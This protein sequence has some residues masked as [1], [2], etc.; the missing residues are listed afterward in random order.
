VPVDARGPFDLTLTP[1]HLGLGAS[2]SPQENFTGDLEW[3][4][5][6]AERTKDDGADGRLVQI[7]D[8][9]ESW[10]SW[11]MHPHGEELVVCV[12]GSF[13]L[14]QERDGQTHSIDLASGEAAINPVGVWHTAD[15][16]GPASALFVTSGLGTE[17]R[18]R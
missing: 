3:Y 4:E 5:R 1:V 12:S 16:R 7:F 15:A 6:Y 9:A 2:I 18:P 10:T 13:T 14:I 8:F 11:E 17:H